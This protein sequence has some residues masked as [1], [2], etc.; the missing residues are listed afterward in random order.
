M[1]EGVSAGGAPRDP[2]GKI[3]DRDALLERY[4]R[5]RAERVV[6]TNGCFDLLHR[7]HVEY[8]FAARSLGDVLVVGLNADASVR[9]LKGAERPIVQQEDR[10]LVLA[11]LECV[12]AVCVFEEDTPR[13]LIARL[14]P[15][16]L[17]KGGDY[18]PE[19]IVGRAEVEAA[20]G[21]VRVHPAVEGYST[22]G[23]ARRLG[24]DSS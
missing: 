20:G 14:L 6:F 21:V 5:P 16:V 13:E 2:R 15:D 4:G 11:S 1:D 10:A 23:L 19:D 3:L 17:I 12:D 24:G 22:T 9:R 18:A 7:G 8:L